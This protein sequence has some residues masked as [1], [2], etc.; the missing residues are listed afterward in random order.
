MIESVL[1]FII[2]VLVYQLFKAREREEVVSYIFIGH[3]QWCWDKLNNLSETSIGQITQLQSEV[4]RARGTAKSPEQCLA[5]VH[6]D[7]LSIKDDLLERRQ[8]LLS[9]LKEVHPSRQ[10]KAASFK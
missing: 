2:V 5:D 6:P 4:L 10:V 7:I 8:Q 9:S 3:A 1:V